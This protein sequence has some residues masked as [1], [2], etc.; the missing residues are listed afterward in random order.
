MTLTSNQSYNTLAGCTTVWN[1][2]IN[3]C[4][5]WSR[6]LS[7][8]ERR[9]KTFFVLTLVFLFCQ[10]CKTMN[11]CCHKILW[12]IRM[13]QL[14]CIIQWMANLLVRQTAVA[15]ATVTYGHSRK[16]SALTSNILNLDGTAIDSKGHIEICPVSLMTSVF[17]EEVRRVVHGVS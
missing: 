1:S 8:T 14:W 4:L 12:S 7:R 2:H 9:L 10:C 16:K 13:I 15:S 6:Q 3:D 11:L 5:M 17:T